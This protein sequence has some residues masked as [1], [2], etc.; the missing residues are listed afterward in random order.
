MSLFKMHSIKSFTSIF[1]ASYLLLGFSQLSLAKEP[2]IKKIRV[3]GNTLIDP[4]LLEDHF[5]LGN[6]LKMNPHIMDLAARES[7]SFYRFHGHP[8]VDSYAIQKGKKGVLT[9]KVNEQREYENG[10]AKAEIA[11]YNLDWNFNMKTTKKQKEEAIR[12]L[13]KGYKKVKLNQEIVAS[14]LIKKQRA[15]IE[16]IQSEEKKAM[17]KNVA[18]AV[19][20]YKGRNLALEKERMQKL[21]E[22]RK[23]AQ[24]AASKKE[25]EE[26]EPKVIEFGEITPFERSAF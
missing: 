6:G 23:R 13:V 19:K 3:K 17:R 10:A 5:E 22:M 20:E 7:R 18:W 16:E 9:L 21:A 8:D 12:K 24:A 14:Y 4:Q 25:M 11:V 15:R 2:F 1:F 26:K